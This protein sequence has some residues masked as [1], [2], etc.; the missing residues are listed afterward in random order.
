MTALTL[1]A[2]KRDIKESTKKLRTHGIVPAVLYGHKVKNVNLAL[3]YKD[4]TKIYREAGENI[5]IDLEV[6]EQKPV[7]V[8]IHDVAQDVVTDKVIHVDFYQVR[9]DEPIHA[10]IP[11]HFM[12]EAPAVKELGG[13]LVKQLDHLPV[14]CLPNDLI[15]SI[16]VDLAVLSDFEKV[17]R[18]SDLSIPRNIEVLKTPDQV[19]VLVTPP[20]VE[21]KAEKEEEAEV[22]EE[23]LEGAPEVKVE[24]TA[25]KSKEATGVKKE[26]G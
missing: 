4:F 8:L 11:I 16:E 13:V 22:T 15:K 19:I 14:K 9:M 1:T 21:E 3:A 17:I 10:E 20:R 23:G 24:G 18:V 6:A 7:K 5:L 2:T 25:E 12:G 26:E